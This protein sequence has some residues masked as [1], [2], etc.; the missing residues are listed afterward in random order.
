MKNN[1]P[2][3]QQEQDYPEGAILASRTDL[4]GIITYA[5]RAFIEISGFTEDELIGENHNMVRH[6]D[7]PPAAFQDLWDT[8]HAGK[9]WTGIVK[10]RC[11][12]GDHYWVKATVT[13][14]VENDQ[15]VE[16]MSVRVKPSRA[17]VQAAETLYAEI[18]AG[19]A[20]LKPKGFARLKYA[21]SSVSIGR[22]LSVAYGILIAL[23]AGAIMLTGLVNM[24]A[25]IKA[26]EARDFNQHRLALEDR[27]KAETRMATAMSALLAKMPDIQ[28]AFADGD[29]DRLLQMLETSFKHL[30]SEYGVRQFQFHTP[31]A[32]SFLR[33][34]KPKKFGD[35][36]TKKRPTIVKTN[37]D[38]QPV[39]G[40]D[41]GVFGLGLR[42]LVQLPKL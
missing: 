8:V 25:G 4:K 22:K 20:S 10:N 7:M 9:P 13:P 11:K 40:V 24:Q 39:A 35:D 16:Y 42:G 12:N 26:N 3:T 6:P 34:H 5:N 28:E 19:R 21:L 17:E 37:A 33:V 38:K 30:K 23:V 41:I 1:Q 36:L 14:V 29:R 15:V 32:T 18:N 31:P 27:L 2:V